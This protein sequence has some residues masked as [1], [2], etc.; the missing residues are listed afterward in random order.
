MKS[1]VRLGWLHAVDASLVL[2][3][4]FGGVAGAWTEAILRGPVQEDI[5]KLRA[6][7]AGLS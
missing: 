7:L 4:R 5:A 3:G 2:V 1:I 6:K